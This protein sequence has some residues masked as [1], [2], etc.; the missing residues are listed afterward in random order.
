MKSIDE[1]FKLVQVISVD[2]GVGDISVTK[3]FTAF[4]KLSR[5][6]TLN[7]SFEPLT[8]FS[9]TEMDEVDFTKIDEDVHSAGRSS[10]SPIKERNAIRDQDT[11]RESQDFHNHNRVRDRDTV[12]DRN[13]IRDHDTIRNRDQGIRQ[14]YSDDADGGK[15]DEPNEYGTLNET[16]GFFEKVNVLA[17]VKNIPNVR[18]NV[19]K[20][21]ISNNESDGGD[22]NNFQ[23]TS[24]NQRKFQGVNGG[25]KENTRFRR[26]RVSRRGRWRSDNRKNHPFKSDRKMYGNQRHVWDG[27]SYAE[28]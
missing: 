22:F 25:G 12:R 17:D 9:E 28:E 19:N 13:A 15:I 23:R 7:Y 8:S 10:R 3:E 5:S 24:G 6:E 20:D 26:N 1:W 2:K 18:M 16:T 4:S 21:M 14:K 11:D 27:T